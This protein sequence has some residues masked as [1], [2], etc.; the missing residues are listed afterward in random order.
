[1][2][3]PNLSCIICGKRFYSRP[4]TKRTTCSI[5]CQSDY[6][7]MNGYSIKPAVGQIN[8]RYNGG[9]TYSRGYKMVLRPEH[10]YK[11]RYGYIRNTRDVMESHLGFILPKGVQIH[12]RN[13]DI[14]D[15]S[16]LNLMVFPDLASHRKYHREHPLPEPYLEEPFVFSQS[17]DS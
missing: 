13:H 11:D 5:K 2:K 1:M 15:D 17:L 14:T 9:I 16:L 6:I 8:H 10:P 12:H 7:Q 3:E 4:S